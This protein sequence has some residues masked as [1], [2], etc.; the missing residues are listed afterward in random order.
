VRRNLLMQYDEI[1]KVLAA[2][3]QKITGG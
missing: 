1:E 2:V 3:D